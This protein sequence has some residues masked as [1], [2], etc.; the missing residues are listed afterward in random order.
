MN[1]PNTT[2]LYLIR[3]GETDANVHGIWNGAT[4]GPLNERGKAQ[5]MATAHRLQNTAHPF[6]AV[7][8][9]PLQRAY[10]TAQT[11]ARALS[12][13]DVQS[14][15]DLAEFNLGE[16]EGLSYEVLNAEKRLWAR[17][18]EDPHWAPPGGESAMQFAMRL[19]RAIR[20][21]GERH[22]GEH[23]VMVSHGGALATA[24]A[25]LLEQN[26]QNWRNYQMTNCGIS[27]LVFD[28]RPRLLFLNDTSHL[29][30]IGKL[31][32]WR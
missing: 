15:P 19:V 1:P 27:A 28:P 10:E 4:D 2:T 14:M 29:E 20:T 11:I 25:M 24:L 5:A 17:M 7:Y 26:G 9:S 16:W 22:P 30:A 3:H 6:T 31:D 32:D 12:I 21:I 23:V 13:P 18:K 8:S